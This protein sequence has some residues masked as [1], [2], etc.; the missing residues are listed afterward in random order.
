MH[1]GL[2]AHPGHTDRVTN[3]LR[4]VDHK[5]LWQYM[6]DTLVGR[7]RD[8]LGGVDYPRDISSSNFLLLDSDDAMRIDTANMAA[9]NASI[10]R[11]NLATGHQLGFFYRALN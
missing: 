7:N 10:N 9:C 5:F 6:Y 3:S 4:I 11:T 1:L 8:G 2:E